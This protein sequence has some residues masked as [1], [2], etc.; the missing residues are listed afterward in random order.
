M[1]TWKQTCRHVNICFRNASFNTNVIG[2][3]SG[4]TW[5]ITLL[6][7][8]LALAMTSENLM[9]THNT[10]N[11]RLMGMK[12][13]AQIGSFIKSAFSLADLAVEKLTDISMG[14]ATGLKDSYH[15]R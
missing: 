4:S 1:Y 8:P 5:L 14:I 12:I 6:S 7:I 3:I 15:E 10:A 13:G 9:D 2:I 11:A